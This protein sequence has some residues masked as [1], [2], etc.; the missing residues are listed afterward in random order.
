MSILSSIAG[1]LGIGRLPSAVRAQLETDGGILYLAESAGATA[2]FENYQA[3][4]FYCSCRKMG[5]IG[6]LALSQKRLAAHAG[7]WDRINLNVPYTDPRFAA[8]SIQAERKTMA[9]SYDASKMSPEASGRVTIRY[10]LPDPEEAA[11]LL[12]SRKSHAE[13]HP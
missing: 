9:L 3:P 13:S 2:T 11:R 10:H 12:Q 6:Y 4:G 7:F 8:I 1:K 5:F